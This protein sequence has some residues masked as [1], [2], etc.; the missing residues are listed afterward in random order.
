MVPWTEP[1][2]QVP[3]GYFLTDVLL[4]MDAL[5]Q[6]RLLQGPKSKVQLAA[7]EAVKLKHLIGGLRALWRSSPKGNHPNVTHLKSLLRPS[8][9]RGSKS[10]SPD[11]PSDPEDNGAEGPDS[12]PEEGE[13]GEEEEPAHDPEVEVDGADEKSFFSGTTLRLPGKGSDGEAPRTESDEDSSSG[14]GSP[15]D[16]HVEHVDDGSSSEEP[17]EKALPLPDSQRE[18]AWM[19]SA[20]AL[21]NGLDYTGKKVVPCTTLY[22]WLVDGKPAKTGEYKGTFYKEDVK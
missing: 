6:G 11:G 2:L 8:P 14:A 22:E 4:R 12:H 19:G 20:Y 15:H 5:F 1:A 13:D 17:C 18:G 3:S 7:D 10:A 9:S 21:Y 16:D